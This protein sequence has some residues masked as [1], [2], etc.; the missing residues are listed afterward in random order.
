MNWRASVAAAVAVMSLLAPICPDV[1]G[2]ETDLPA[3]GNN[4]VAYYVFDSGGPDHYPMPTFTDAA[5]IVVVFEGT[6]WELADSTHYA[7]SWMRNV[8]YHSHAEV[9]RD[10]K[11]LQAQGVKVLMNVDDAPSWSSATPFTTYDGTQLNVQEF[12]AFIK[13]CAIDSVGLDGISLDIEHGA[14]GNS[15][16]I[17]LIKEIGKYFGPLSP[18]STSKMYIAAI[19]AGGVPGPVIGKSRETTA[20]MNFIMDMAYFV[21]D[22]AARF[23]QW[24]DSIG[25][26]KTMIGVLNDY[27]D[28]SHAMSAAAWQ[29]ASPPKAGIMVYAANNLKAYTDAVFNALAVPTGADTDP[30]PAD[31]IPEDYVLL[32]NYPNPFNASTV[33]RFIVGGQGPSRVRLTVSDMLGR[34]VAVLVDETRA[35]GRYEA[36]WEAAGLPSG[37][38]FCRLTA[39]AYVEV[40]A[41]VLL[42]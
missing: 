4:K 5:N 33:M 7:T 22:Y 34:E 30:G 9:L 3:P 2:A 11:A 32:Q 24:A 6:L 35:P 10:I 41:M 31:R 29:P 27:Y 17:S 25:S 19:Y 28:V 42:K 8:N 14:T 15:T 12:A 40:K 38:Y 26:S 13:A 1:R 39:D 16:Y 37:V 21:W 36:R 23:R 20:Y 18:D